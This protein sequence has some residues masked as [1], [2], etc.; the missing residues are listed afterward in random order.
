MGRERRNIY[1]IENVHQY[2]LLK[3]DEAFLDL[4]FLFTNEGYFSYW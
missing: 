4:D 3:H 1:S 2:W